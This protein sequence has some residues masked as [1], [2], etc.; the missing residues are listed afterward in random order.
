MINTCPL[1][2]SSDHAMTSPDGNDSVLRPE[3]RTSE[4]TATNHASTPQSPLMRRART[5]HSHKTTS[6]DPDQPRM[7]VD[8]A[9]LL[10]T[11]EEAAEL[12][13]VGRSRVY[14]LMRARLLRS[15]K[16]GRSRRV[17]AA[18]LRDFVASL[19][20]DGEYE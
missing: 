19:A 5:V 11:P 4:V 7:E 20:R 12:L 16:I 8:Q 2:G 1:C 14:D 9:K 18:S 10:L 6:R 17:P 3:G 15:V 13:G